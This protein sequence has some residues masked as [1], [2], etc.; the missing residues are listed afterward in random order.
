MTADVLRKGVV[1]QR[2]VATLV[3]GVSGVKSIGAG[4]SFTAALKSDGSLF[5]WGKNDRG[6]LGDGTTQMH[7]TPASMN[8]RTCARSSIG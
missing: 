4:L 7:S 6:Q 2:L 8:R 5:L 1:H 3:N